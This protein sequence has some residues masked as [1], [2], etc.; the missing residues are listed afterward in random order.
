MYGTLPK[1][2]SFRFLIRRVLTN[3]TE[4]LLHVYQVSLSC[5]ALFKSLR[6]LWPFEVAC[7]PPYLPP[8]L[9]PHQPPRE[10]L[11]KLS[12]NVKFVF[13]CNLICLSLRMY[14]VRGYLLSCVE[15]CI[16]L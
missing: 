2:V 15:T 6:N 7:P 5:K 8:P 11:Q 1:K 13:T 4:I 3:F 14:M 10:L 9:P 16:C 12:A